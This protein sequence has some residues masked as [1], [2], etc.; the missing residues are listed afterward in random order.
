MTISDGCYIEMNAYVKGGTLRAQQGPQ[1]G[2]STQ[3]VN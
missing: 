1:D 2:T 3:N